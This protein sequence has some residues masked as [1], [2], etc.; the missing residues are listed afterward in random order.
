MEETFDL[1]AS[2]SAWR[3][4]KLWEKEYD[5][6]PDLSIYVLDLEGNC[7]NSPQSIEYRSGAL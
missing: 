2:R 5:T 3:I 7:L 6:V 1:M 4:F